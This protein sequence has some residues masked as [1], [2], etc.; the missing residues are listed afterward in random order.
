M[1]STKRKRGALRRGAVRCSGLRCE[2]D[3]TLL[4]L[5]PVPFPSIAG[6]L[7][8]ACD[9]L[10]VGA[11]DPTALLRLTA[12]FSGA[13]DVTAAVGRWSKGT[14][15]NGEGKRGQHA[16]ESGQM[17]WTRHHCDSR[18]AARKL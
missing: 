14:R 16:R 15:N 7:P 13:P 5:P 4:S 11:P 9:R 6:G 1:N 8:L 2:R 12:R 10:R 17:R 18:S 3:A